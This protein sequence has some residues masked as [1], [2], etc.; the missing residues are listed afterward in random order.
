M[1]YLCL[2][3]A[4]EIQTLKPTYSRQSAPLHFCLW[5]ASS[6][7]SNWQKRPGPLKKLKTKLDR[8]PCKLTMFWLNRKIFPNYWVKY[9]KIFSKVQFTKIWM[10]F[11]FISLFIMSRMCLEQPKTVILWIPTTWRDVIVEMHGKK[12]LWLI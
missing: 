5:Y 6:A 1:C 10:E 12:L 4:R 11:L 8:F 7:Y 3:G 2:S 9:R